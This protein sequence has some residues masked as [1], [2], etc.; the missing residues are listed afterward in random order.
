VKRTDIERYLVRWDLDPEESKKAYA[1]DEFVQEDW[2]LL[3]FMRKLGLPYPLNDDGTAKGETFKLW[4]RELPLKPPTQQS[5][6][7]RP[8][9]SGNSLRKPWWK[10]W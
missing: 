4:T 6:K 10:F 7:Q 3:D 1:D 8:A 9:S 2:Q 5:E